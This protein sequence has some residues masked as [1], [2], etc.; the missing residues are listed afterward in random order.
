MNIDTIKK[1]IAID[2][3]HIDIANKV[4]LHKHNRQDELFYCV[5]GH[6]YGVLEGSEVEISEGKVFIVPRETMHAFRTDG[7]I[8]STFFLIPVV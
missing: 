5:A 1:E 2:V 4:P 7:D 8:Y 6:G 3:Y